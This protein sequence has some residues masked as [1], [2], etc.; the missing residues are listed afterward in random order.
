MDRTLTYGMVE[1][2]EEKVER[3]DRESAD[4]KGGV[5][6]TNR[7]YQIFVRMP[8]QSNHCVCASS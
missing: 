2:V 3:K 8:K 4:R 1:T 5:I 6:K 7:K